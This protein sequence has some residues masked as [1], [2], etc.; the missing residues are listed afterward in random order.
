MLVIYFTQSIRTLDNNS[1]IRFFYIISTAFNDLPQTTDTKQS[2][3][4]EL[5]TTAPSR[6]DDITRSSLCKSTLLLSPDV[7]SRHASLSNGLHS[8]I[9][10]KYNHISVMMSEECDVTH[11]MN[12]AFY[13]DE[14]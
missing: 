8:E 7:A 12:S 10:R 13:E 6:V 1:I 4:D 2:H 3:F 5:S 14:R 11:I 9:N